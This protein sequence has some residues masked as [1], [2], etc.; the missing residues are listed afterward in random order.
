MRTLLLGQRM[1]GFT[2]DSIVATADELLSK[3][4]QERVVLVCH[5]TPLETPEGAPD[6]PAT[7]PKLLEVNLHA[8]LLAQRPSAATESKH[9]E[10]KEYLA[11]KCD[12]V[13]RLTTGWNKLS[14]QIN[15]RGRIIEFLKSDAA[16]PNDRFVQRLLGFDLPVTRLALRAAL[17]IA[18]EEL[19]GGPFEA[20]G[21]GLPADTLL[22]PALELARRE[23]SLSGWVAELE[24]SL[25][26]HEHLRTAIR[27]VLEALVQN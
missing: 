11:G 16:F 1:L 20:G 6:A 7:C 22:A 2:D 24:S 14:E 12:R 15:E 4:D 27:R 25:G 17:E 3:V 19:A 10:L 21:S 8:L 9:Q 5:G 26:N 13:Y 23:P 18:S